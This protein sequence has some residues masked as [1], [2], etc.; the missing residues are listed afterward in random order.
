V[1]TSLKKIIQEVSKIPDLD[2]ALAR[3]VTMVKQTMEV[4]SC[5]IYLSNQEQ[6]AVVLRATDGLD[7]AA[8]GVVSIGLNEGLIGLVGDRE[9]PLNIENAPQHPRFKHYPEV[10]EDSYHAFL[11]APIM[12]QRK[13]LGVITMQQSDA[14]R[15]SEDDEAFLVTLAAQIALEI[16]NAKMRSG[17]TFPNENSH[18]QPRS[19]NGI[20]GSPGLALGTG[21]VANFKHELSQLLPRKSA[22]TD[23][24]ISQYRK[25]VDI[26][27]AQV[28]ALSANLSDKLPDDVSAIFQLYDQLLDANSLGR[29]VEQEIHKG[30]DAATSLKFVVER[31][32]TRFENMEDP[33]MRERA[34]DIIDLSNRILNNILSNDIDQF[35]AIDASQS[36]ILVAQE[37]SAPMLAEFPRE[38][39]AGIISIKGSNNSHAAILARAMGVPAVM[40]LQGVSLNL[41][42]AKELF[43]DGYSGKVVTRFNEKER[44]GFQHLID[45]EEALYRK[46]SEDG[47]QP[48]V[49]QDNQKFSLLVNAG[50]TANLEMDQ[51]KQGDGIGLYRTEIPFMMRDRFPSEQEQVELYGNVLAAHPSK[52]IT[53]RTL[54]VGGDKPLSYFPIAEENPFLGWRGIRLTLDHPDIFLVQVR[55]ML[56]ASIGL[57]NLHILLPMISGVQEVDDANRLIKQAFLE[58]KEEAMANNLMLSKP[59]VGIMLEVPSVLFQLKELAQ[60]VDFFSVGTND[61]TQYLLA[62]DRNNPRVSSLYSSYHP[63]VLGALNQIRIGSEKYKVPVTVCGEAAGEPLGA[64]ILMAM[65]FRKLSM[66][67][68]SLRKINWVIRHINLKEVQTLLPDILAQ[69]TPEQVRALVHQYIESKQLGGLIRAG[70]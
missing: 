46:I 44:I 7:R 69:Q 43:I 19:L 45:E 53:M 60:R 55:A 52:E 37:V 61:L 6:S 67:A 38:R 5:S 16:V 36:C 54:D 27:R 63:A 57:T 2:T 28:T 41:L 58:V 70:A 15:F 59:A 62:V 13:V 50:L 32:A 20:P 21:F 17:I 22:D 56:R 33:Y 51:F 39:L 64:V 11:G 4:D 8:I 65:G 29:E 66:N 47:D 48:S 24:Q 3:L 49:T 26:T 31:Y 1:L 35:S 14:R 23:S 25:A 68:H 42:K 34:V 18:K 30:W 10:K 12:H 9:E 40:G